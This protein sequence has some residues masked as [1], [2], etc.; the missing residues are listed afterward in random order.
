MEEFPSGGEPRL[1]TRKRSDSAEYAGFPLTASIS[2]INKD[3]RQFQLAKSAIMSGIRI[4]CKN[5]SLKPEDIANVY[6]AGGFGFFINK[7]NAVAAGLLPKEFLD[8][9]TVCGNLSLRGAEEALVTKD[10]MERC[11]QIINRCS[12]IDLSLDP[13]F[14]DEFTENMLFC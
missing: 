10:F 6:I 13:E 3:I 14:M 5:G 1:T 7:K 2:I 8:S 12:V 11:R 9:I 4:L